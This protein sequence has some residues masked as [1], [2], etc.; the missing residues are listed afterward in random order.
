[1]RNE[2]HIYGIVTEQEITFIGCTKGDLPPGEIRLQTVSARPKENW[3]RFRRTLE[4]TPEKGG[5]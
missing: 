1:M 5:R 3:V 2:F 4:Q